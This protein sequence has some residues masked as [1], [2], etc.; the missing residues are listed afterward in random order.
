MSGVVDELIC[1][2]VAKGSVLKGLTWQLSSIY[3]SIQNSEFQEAKLSVTRQLEALE[4]F[5]VKQDIQAG[6]ALIA[7]RKTLEQLDHLLEHLNRLTADLGDLRTYL[8]LRTAANSFDEEAKAESS[9]M[10]MLDTR[11]T[12]L[13]TGWT[14]WLG[15]FGEQDLLRSPQTKQH[16]YQLE[17]KRTEARHQMSQEAEILEGQLHA[18]ARQGWA[19]LH[20]TLLSQ[21]TIYKK[22]KG[23]AKHYTVTDLENL[24]LDPSENVRK[25][26]Y[27]AE[28]ELVTQHLVSYTAALNGVKGY[29]NT[30]AKARGWRSV[31]EASL[32]AEGISQ[33]CLDALYQA[34]RESFPAFRRFLKL[35]AKALGKKQLAWYDRFLPLSIG[36]QKTYTWDEAKQ[37]VLE[38]F[39]SYS[40]TLVAF[41][42]RTFSE[43]WHDVSPRKGKT[44]G[45]FCSEP[46]TR[47]KESRL[48]HNFSGQLGDV[49]ILA[50]ELGH[51][52]HAECLFEAKRT[53]LQTFY[54]MTLAETASTF[55]ELIVSQEHLKTLSDKEKLTYLGQT[56][57]EVS[58]NVL[59]IHSRFL[60]EQE[61]CEARLEREL[62]SKELRQF[63]LSAQKQTFGNS[64]SVFHDLMWVTRDHYYGS[65]Y[66]NFPYTFGQ[67]LSLGLYKEYERNPQTFPERFDTLL[68]STSMTDAVTLAKEFGIDIEDVAF[69][70]QSLSVPLGQI[71]I[72]EGL[73]KKYRPET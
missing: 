36:K 53:P 1:N 62:S 18:S 14:A 41:A 13:D 22:I 6:N 28:R 47:T 20:N 10:N 24:Q 17:C 32:F 33:T 40:P 30:V 5:F 64:F 31:L 21:T 65:D 49:C 27:E 3:P 45:A 58:Q 19:D 8:D 48:L 59:D 34:C 50:H 66:Y 60:F 57:F 11:L 70:R 4:A 15:R 67:L 61:V 69:W 25:T 71:A 72:F 54:P 52:Y 42:Q 46:I 44:G 12:L 39:R 56:I 16:A 73:V 51:A 43:G 29:A 63:M 38:H 2:E 7:D 23:A 26:A 35:K 9:S 55:C 68:A 37:I